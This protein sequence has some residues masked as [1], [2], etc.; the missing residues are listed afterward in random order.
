[1]G[2]RL[3][4]AATFVCTAVF[5]LGVWQ[6][7][8]TPAAN[9]VDSGALAV[10]APLLAVAVCLRA[11]RRVPAERFVWWAAGAAWLCNLAGDLV[12]L[13]LLAGNPDPPFPSAADALWLA[14]YPALF[15]TPVLMVHARLARPRPGTWLDGLV[16]ALGATAVAVAVLDPGVGA[17]DMSA[18]GV[19]VNLAYPVADV[20]LLALVGAVLAMIGHR[21]DLVLTTVCVIVAV[22][23]AGDLLLAREQAAGG[24]V[25][26]GP[27]DLLWMVNASLTAAAAWLTRPRRRAPDVPEHRVRWR[28]LAIP[29]GCAVGSLAVLGARW[30]DGR[31]GPDEICALACLAA[32]LVRS[33]VTFAESRAL[34]EAGRQAGTDDLTG[35]PNRRSL[36]RRLEADLGAARPTGVLLL[37]LDGFKA[38][39]DGLGHEAGDELLRRL[40]QRLQEVLRPTDLV[41]RLGGDEFVV[42][43]DTTDPD[44]APEC[45]ERLAE[46]VRRPVTVAGVPV[47]VGVSIG[48]ALAPRDAAEP[49]ALLRCADVAMYAAKGAG[50]GVRHHAPG[51]GDQVPSP[52]SP[53]TSPAAEADVAPSG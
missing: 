7:P 30:G 18:L 27:L 52:R 14:A 16:G 24:Y 37:D 43:L 44:V 25:P 20:L 3:V 33:A 36:M 8:G 10:A 26:G 21:A 12:H 15:A 17:A 32:F 51:T 38:V 40:S 23:F 29:L 48:L 53:A 49:A 41:A 50:G 13:A 9:L 28:S 11:A 5:A 34:H 39:N 19:A 2:W 4:V 35:L 6:S 46:V 31:T 47:R 22:K 1:M 45:A 42:V